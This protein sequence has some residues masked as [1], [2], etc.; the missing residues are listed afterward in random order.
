MGTA[1]V[2]RKAAAAHNPVVFVHGYNADP[3]VWGQLKDDLKAAGYTDSELFAW[4]Y[5]SSQSVNEV[6]A[7]QFASYVDSVRQQ[8]G[9]A[10]VDVVTHSFGSLTG[11]WYVKFGGGQATVRSLV[12]LGGPNHGTSTAYLCAWDQA[13][14]DMTP[15]SYVQT[16]LASG[17]ETPGAVRYATFW[18]SCDEVINPDDSVQLNGAT[19]V[20]VGCLDHNDLLFDDGVSAG[21]RS[22]L[23]G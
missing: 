22:F 10:Q 2:P 8:T 23:A 13:C 20:A 3:G 12:S 21:V 14:R 15:N 6:L 11:R 1:A 7:G 16:Q 5:D 19:N 17:D 18:S 4:G 9:A